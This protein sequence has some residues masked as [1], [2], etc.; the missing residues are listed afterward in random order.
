MVEQKKCW[1]NLLNTVFPNEKGFVVVYGEA[2]S[3]KTSLSLTLASLSRKNTLYI[4]T[5][6]NPTYERAVQVGM[7]PNIEFSNDIDEWGIIYDTLKV[8]RIKEFFI[9]DSINN[10]YRISASYDIELA[11]R[12]FLFICS[13]FRELSKRSMVLAT[14]QV[15]LSGDIPSGEEVLKHYSTAMIKLTR[16]GWKREGI[17]EVEGRIFGEYKLERGGFEWISC[18]Q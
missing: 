1:D 14:A 16:K 15:S 12:T 8:W 11:F 5:E 3:G 17:L 7:P 2:G 10:V 4:N 18:E 6:G 9:I 13:L